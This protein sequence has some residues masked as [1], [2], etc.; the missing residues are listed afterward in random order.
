MP[1][2]QE[3]EVEIVEPQEHSDRCRGCKGGG[4]GIAEEY[5]IDVVGPLA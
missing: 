1:E 5:D 2:T 4:R 3:Y